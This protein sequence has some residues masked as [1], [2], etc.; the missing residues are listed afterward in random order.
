M[1]TAGAN[2]IR[3]T[4][5]FVTVLEEMAAELV[6]ATTPRGDELR[7]RRRGR[8]VRTPLATVPA[9]LVRAQ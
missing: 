5:A 9:P 7:A 8:P 4:L 1:T 6:A 2:R 3:S